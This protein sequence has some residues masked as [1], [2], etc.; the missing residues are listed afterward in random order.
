MSIEKPKRPILQAIHDKFDTFPRYQYTRHDEI[1]QIT[2]HSTDKGYK[3][4]TYPEGSG[5]GFDG[6]TIDAKTN[7]NGGLF[8]ENPPT[9]IETYRSSSVESVFPQTRVEKLVLPGDEGYELFEELQSQVRA[10]KPLIT[11]TMTL[12]V[13]EHSAASTFYKKKGGDIIYDRERRVS[14]IDTAVYMQ[15]TDALGK[16]ILVGLD[17]SLEI[18]FG[19]EEPKNKRTIFRGGWVEKGGTKRIPLADEEVIAFNDVQLQIDKLYKNPD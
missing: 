15:E 17:A 16:K 19:Q 5:R 8:G 4:T 14:I 6:F 12:V 1:S 2:F 3:L 7:G 10:L 9:H 18:P 13:P 11:D